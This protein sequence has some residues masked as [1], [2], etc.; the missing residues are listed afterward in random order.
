ME[1]T[2]EQAISLCDRNAVAARLAKAEEVRD[3][4]LAKFPLDGWPTM[5]LERYALGQEARGVACRLERSGASGNSSSPRWTNGSER[6]V[7]IQTN[8]VR[9]K[10]DESCAD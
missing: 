1:H 5:P 9:T 7:Q 4:I 6:A 3:E 10:S 2:L 8:P